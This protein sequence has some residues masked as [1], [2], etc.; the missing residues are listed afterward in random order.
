MSKAVETVPTTLFGVA[1]LQA[2]DYDDVKRIM[3]IVPHVKEFLVLSP[4]QEKPRVEVSKYFTERNAKLLRIRPAGVWNKFFRELQDVNEKRLNGH[5]SQ[6]GDLMIIS[7]IQAGD[8]ASAMRR[9]RAAPLLSSREMYWLDTLEMPESSDD[10]IEMA[11]RNMPIVPVP[12]RYS[13]L[14]TATIF[15]LSAYDSLRY[16]RP[17]HCPKSVEL[18][19]EAIPH[20]LTK[21]FGPTFA[22]YGCEISR[23]P[24]PA[25]VE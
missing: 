17:T 9:H 16:F 12:V 11:L 19:M 13:D 20:Y 8:I 5:Y 3:G 10:A 6:V 22:K 7:I 23:L 2:K 18:T 15:S 24:V 25:R 21:R 14:D 1:F 4:S